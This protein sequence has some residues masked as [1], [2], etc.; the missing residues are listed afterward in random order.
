MR[1]RHVCGIVLSRL[2]APDAFFSVTGGCALSIDAPPIGR[3]C[4]IVVVINVTLRV[5]IVCVFQ[6]LLVVNTALLEY[7][8]CMACAV[9][10]IPFC[11][12][13]DSAVR[14]SPSCQTMPS[15]VKNSWGADWGM[16]GYVLLE[17][18]A[19]Q[20]GGECGILMMPS[21]PVLA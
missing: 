10:D 20:E 11:W 3:Q 6:V 14:V 8:R 17:R 21:Y 19:P 2:G 13:C 16:D 4:V 15:Q 7:L 18:E 12:C 9:G 5:R 1:A